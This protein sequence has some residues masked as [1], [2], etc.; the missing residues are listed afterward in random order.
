MAA[1]FSIFVSRCASN[2]SRCLKPTDANNLNS[3]PI[4]QPFESNVSD[5][6]LNDMCRC[7]SV[8]CTKLHKSKP[9]K[10]SS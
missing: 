4:L 8:D 2:S 6:T 7:I 5:A 9:Y 3:E 1:K 10:A